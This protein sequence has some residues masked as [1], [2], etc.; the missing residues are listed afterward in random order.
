M[1][2]RLMRLV[3]LPLLAVAYAAPMPFPQLRL[4]PGEVDT[5]QVHEAGAD[6]AEHS[7]PGAYASG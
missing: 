7:H 1:T 6:S 3:L 2:T 5:M 4:P